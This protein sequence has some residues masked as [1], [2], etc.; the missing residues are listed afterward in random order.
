M[1]E[2]LGDSSG[3]NSPG[4]K[5]RH[6]HFFFGALCTPHQPQPAQNRLGHCQEALNADT[7]EDADTQG[8]VWVQS[9]SAAPEQG[10]RQHAEAQTAPQYQDVTSPAGN[11]GP[12]SILSPSG[13]PLPSSE[14]G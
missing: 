1:Q 5:G 2:L 13:P 12:G 9:G 4:R 8:Q 11:A 3:G 14:P 7:L 10:C 6:C